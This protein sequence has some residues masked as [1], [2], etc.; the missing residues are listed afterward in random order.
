[1]TVTITEDNTLVEVKCIDT[2]GTH[3]LYQETLGVGEQQI[4]V[5]ATSTTRGAKSL[6]ILFNGVEQFRETVDVTNGG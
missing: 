6:I 5:Q 2:D 3:T 1:M 4:L